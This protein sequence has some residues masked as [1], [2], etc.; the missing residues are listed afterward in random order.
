MSTHTTARGA[1]AARGEAGRG[2][3]LGAPLDLRDS[4]SR[5]FG[6]G[7]VVK[8]VLMALIN[9]FGLYGILAAW[10]AGNWGILAFLVVALVVADLV[11]F[12][13]TRKML[14]AKYLYPGLIFLLIFQIFVVLYTA[15]TAFTNYGDGHN[16]TKAA[17]I[18]QLTT[19]YEQ[20]VEG[21]APY[22]VTVV[23]GGAGL[24]LATVQEGQVLVGTA[25]QP[26][27]PVGDAAVTDGRVAEVPGYE[28]LSYTE[29]LGAQDQLS[30]LRVPVSEQAED[31]A[32]R[33]DD[34]RTAYA[35]DPT[36]VYD[37]GADAMVADDGTVYT[38][39]SEGAFVNSDGEALSP[40]WRVFVGLDNFAA[41]FDPAILGGP[42]LAVTLW[43]FTF[44]ILSVA[45]T[46]F[47]GLLLAILFNDE[48]LKFRNVYRAIIF[49]PYAFPAF[50]SILIWAGLLNTDY[51]F[52]NEILLG[53][54][55]VP[56][57]DNPWLARIS[58]LL[59]NLWLGFPYMFLVTTGALQAIP[60]ELYESAEMDGAGPVRQFGSITLPM[61]MVAV[62][63]LLIA[64]F[65]MN[66]NNFN[67]IYLLTGGG[68][69]DV[70]STTG[71][72]ATDIL[73]SFVYKIAFAGGSND[74]GLA[75]AL[76]ILIFIM[77]A[78]ISGLTFRR[79]KAL[80]EI[81]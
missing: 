25:E 70:E 76:S 31:G 12:L 62:G 6:L 3:G 80:E 27:A 72:G 73:I 21:S 23:E 34:G 78:V 40:G 8:L 79:S 67:V 7:F 11:Y 61:L 60:G 44:A 64:S 53:G 26:L 1:T 42:F 54:A 18:S 81:S 20:R 35:Y 28:V 51:G 75:A 63:P 32:L 45:L 57:L 77:V 13:P 50:L 38:N 71:V 33:T 66:F 2:A 46:F 9:A 36:L 29:V 37:E 22:P 17:A 56:W 74:Y 52:V 16:A 41:I 30:E 58:L 39:N 24:A 68:P 14:P 47:L 19:T 43:T 4:H 10:A 5:G 55:G 69:Q 65:A 48:K 49:L 59:V 15:A